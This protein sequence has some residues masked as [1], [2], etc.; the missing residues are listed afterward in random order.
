[1]IAFESGESA[2]AA[3]LIA[4]MRAAVAGA[5]QIPD[6]DDA[7]EQEMLEERLFRMGSR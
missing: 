1:V 5:G 7:A 6:P 3:E 2:R 4:A